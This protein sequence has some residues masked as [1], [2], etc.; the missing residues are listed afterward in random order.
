MEYLP[1]PKDPVFPTA[2]VTFHDPAKY[3]YEGNWDEYIKGRYWDNFPRRFGFTEA[4]FW[5][6]SGPYSNK[7]WAHAG[8]HSWLMQ[9]PREE[10]EAMAIAWLFYGTLS[11]VTCC[12]LDITHYLKVADDGRF[13]LSMT[14][15]SMNAILERWRTIQT[16]FNGS[17]HIRGVPEPVYGLMVDPDASRDVRDDI[18]TKFNTPTRP[19]Q[20]AKLDARARS[21]QFERAHKCLRKSKAVIGLLCEA[22]DTKTVFVIANLHEFLATALTQFIFHG[23]VTDKY[24]LDGP[25]SLGSWIAGMDF[26]HYTDSVHRSLGWCPRTTASMLR[27][28]TRTLAVDHFEINLESHQASED[29]SRCSEDICVAYQLDPETYKTLHFGGKLGDCSCAHQ[30]LDP[31]ISAAVLLNSSESYPLIKVSLEEGAEEDLLE[32]LDSASE[33]SYV[34]ISHVWSHGLGNPKSNSLPKCQL[35]RIQG[36]VNE[37]ASQNSVHENARES[38][39]FWM[40]TLCCPIE[41]KEFRRAAIMKM[42]LTYQRASHVLVIDQNL[43]SVSSSGLSKLE[44]LMRIYRTTWMTRLWTL[45]EARFA[46]KLWFLFK[47]KP[48]NLE[49]LNNEFLHEAKPSSTR[50]LSEQLFVTTLSS[51]LQALR[52]QSH[53]Q[54]IASGA[55][56]GAADHVERLIV[57]SYSLT[58]RSTSWAGDEAI[59]ICALMGLDLASIL[60]YSPEEPASRMAAMW[61]QWRTVPPDIIFS[62]APRLLEEGYRW[63]QSTFIRTSKSLMAVG[64]INESATVDIEGEG[65]LLSMQGFLLDSTL[66]LFVAENKIALERET[67]SGATRTA[68]TQGLSTH[69]TFLIYDPTGNYS[70]RKW[71]D[72]Q[73]IS[74]VHETMPEF[75]RDGGFAILFQDRP[76]LQSIDHRQRPAL[77]AAVKKSKADRTYVTSLYHL[78]VAPSE[79]AAKRLFN[80]ALRCQEV[81]ASYGQSGI[82]PPTMTQD[83][84][85][86]I[87]GITAETLS[88]SLVQS[89][90]GATFL[91]NRDPSTLEWLSA[92]DE[93]RRNWHFR[94]TKGDVAIFK[95]MIVNVWMNLSCPVV[96][97]SKDS[98]W[99][100]D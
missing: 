12:Y 65:L 62:R 33:S 29:H 21:M 52:E 57:L 50:T 28:K 67:D 100:V 13:V 49:T 92:S 55:K 24:D 58:S 71:F 87:D 76:N 75:D 20:T 53:T 37:L 99:C 19:G 82:Q 17:A 7:A 68:G 86:L 15:R 85:S 3:W 25:Y 2:E 90:M 42:S 77:L 81:V 63:A 80:G 26:R 34:A 94:A 30:E 1:L 40:D 64:D 16:H 73:I 43:C 91:R 88:D 5:D 11:E 38:V 35:R 39:P 59:C 41:P 95:T 93:R 4:E 23:E 96:P 69:M 74:P 46:E 98:K 72:V 78:L 89:Y 84:L 18:L 54:M 60:E 10:M 51:H 8:F 47:D 70:D 56:Q 83:D 66:P 48:I 27:D 14:E 6:E 22:I 31:A 61:K 97:V 79:T 45:Q 9:Q 32:V 44:M 36:C